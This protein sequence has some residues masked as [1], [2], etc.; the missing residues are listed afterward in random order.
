MYSSV[1]IPIINKY[2]T[3]Q[4]AKKLRDIGVTIIGIGIT[5]EVNTDI[6]R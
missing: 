6:M 5:K 3:F 1:E 4:T 2:W